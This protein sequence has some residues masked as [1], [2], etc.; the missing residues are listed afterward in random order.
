MSYLE[1]FKVRI[2]NREFSKFIQLWEEY[3]TNDVVD[4]EELIQL[5]RMIKSSDLAKAFG[6]TVEET[7]PLLDVIEDKESRYNVLKLLI[8]LQTT[9]SPSLADLALIYL[10]ENFENDPS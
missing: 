3:C 7:I 1:E 9:N 2:N 10:K 8:D 4:V 5:L 6:P